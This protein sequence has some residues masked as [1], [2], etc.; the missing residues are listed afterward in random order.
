[1]MDHQL[2]NRYQR[3]TDEGSV[4]ELQYKV[5]GLKHITLQIREEIRRQKTDLQVIR[6]YSHPLFYFL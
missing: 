5:T 3:H 2:L 4:E 1:M 6:G